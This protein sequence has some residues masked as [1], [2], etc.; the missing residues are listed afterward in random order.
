MI[1]K[2]STF[3][4]SD[5]MDTLGFAY[6]KLLAGESGY[7]PE[8]RIVEVATGTMLLIKSLIGSCDGSM[9]TDEESDFMLKVAKIASEIMIDI[10]SSREDFDRE[11]LG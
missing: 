8:E 1:I 9:F 2:R 11:D 7:L 3:E 5:M 4:I 10:T 6:D